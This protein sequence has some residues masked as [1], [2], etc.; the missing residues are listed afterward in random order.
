MFPEDSTSFD[1]TSQPLSYKNFIHEVLVREATVYM[2]QQDLGLDR[3]KAIN[4]LKHSQAF[5]TLLHPG[6]DS[7]HIQAVIDKTTRSFQRQKS[8][9]RLWKASDT[10]L[11]LD[12]WVLEQKSAN[13][14][15]HIKQE[16]NDLRLSSGGDAVMEQFGFK[17]VTSG[18]KV[19]YELID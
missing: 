4:T 17:A 1:P 13:G 14:V 18:S 2:I 6:D 15:A 7:P 16:E 11:S 12:D 10:T 19:I 8:L 5:G 9:F 3:K